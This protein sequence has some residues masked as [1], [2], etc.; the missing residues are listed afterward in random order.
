[1]KN[2]SINKIFLF[3]LSLAVIFFSSMIIIFSPVGKK[4]IIKISTISAE[5]AINIV[6]D[7]PEVVRENQ[8]LF[9]K[10]AKSTLYIEAEP[11][12]NDSNFHIYY[13]EI[14]LDHQ[15][16]LVSF[17]VNSQT[18]EVTVDNIIEPTPI[19]YAVWQKTC[20]LQSCPKTK[21]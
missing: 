17:L 11:T 15:N 4:S 3:P 2:K 9:T 13:G 19:T 18:G 8:Y 7:L 14:Q 12:K 20:Q 21:K 5:E 16:R 10:K 6:A 1:M